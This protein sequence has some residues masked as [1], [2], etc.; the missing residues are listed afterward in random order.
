MVCMKWEQDTA[1]YNQGAKY[2]EV[3]SPSIV[4]G[5]DILLAN[6]WPT[7]RDQRNIFYQHGIGIERY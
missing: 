3:L 6:L 4:F 2:K 7:Q 5:E 1:A